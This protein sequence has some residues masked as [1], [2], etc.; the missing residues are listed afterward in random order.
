MVFHLKFD[1]TKTEDQWQLQTVA[2]LKS[3]QGSELKDFFRAKLVCSDSFA[4]AWSCCMQV[5]SRL[6]LTYYSS[7]IR[8]K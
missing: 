7:R 8:C 2:G 5:N 4:C 1:E 3:P 6:Y